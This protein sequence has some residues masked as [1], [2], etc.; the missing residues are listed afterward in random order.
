M[1]I[2]S[3]VLVAILNEEPEAEAFLNA[4]NMS[5][6]MIGWPTIL[7]TRIWTIRNRPEGLQPWLDGLLNSP[8]TSVID[9]NGALEA[10]AAQAYAQ[11]GKGRHPAKLNYGD[12]MAYAVARHQNL[13]LLFKGA[14]FG[15]TD[16]KVHPHSVLTA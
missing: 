14:D 6:R 9:F 10:L 5:E 13:P 7:E 11:F 4:I 15:L 8:I 12:C 16:V 1:A 2:D 3:S